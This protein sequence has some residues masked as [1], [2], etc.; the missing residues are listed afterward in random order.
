MQTDLKAKS[1]DDL[2]K[3]LQEAYHRISEL[4]TLTLPSRQARRD[5]NHLNLNTNYEESFIDLKSILDTEYIQDMMSDFQKLTGAAFAILDLNGNILV[6]SGWQDICT[7]F[8]RKHPESARN[9]SKSDFYLEKNA[10]PGRYVA[11]RCGNNLWDIVTPLYIGKTHVGNIYAGQF[12]YDDETVDVNKF[13]KQAEKYGFDPKKYLEA[14]DKVPRFKRTHVEHLMDFLLKITIFISNLG[15]QNLQLNKVV[16][17]LQLTAG[18]L[19]ESDRHF[20]ALITQA[21]IP[22]IV[23]DGAG[24]VEI[25]NDRFEATFGYTR[26][27]IPNKNSWLGLA[28]PYAS[29]RVNANVW[30]EVD[31]T[32]ITRKDIGDTL[33][34]YLVTCK[35]GKQR[36]TEATCSWIGDNAI[37]IY[38]DI[39]DRKQA[40]RHL[41]DSEERLKNLYALSPI[42]IFLSVP[43]GYYLDANKALS[44]ILGYT[45][46]EDLIFSVKSISKQTFFNPSDWN[47]I[48]CLLKKD[49]VMIN[50]IV[51]RKKKD[52]S[53][54]WVLMNM[55]TVY[56]KSGSISHFDGFTVDITEQKNTESLLQIQYNFANTLLEALPNPVFYKNIHGKYIGCNKAWEELLGIP[57]KNIIG[58]SVF[59]VFPQQHA[60]VYRT[61]DDMLFDEEVKQE[62]ETTLP[63][64][65]GARNVILSKAIYH[66]AQKNTVGLIGVVT[67]ITDRK[68]EQAALAESEN[69]LRNIFENAPIGI[70]QSTPNGRYRTVNA[71]FSR[72]VG[73]ENPQDMIDSIE[74][75]SSLYIDPNQREEFKSILTVNGVVSD[76]QMHIRR[77]DGKTMWMSAYAKAIHNQE[78]DSIY[79]DGFALDISERKKAEE[80]VYV[81]KNYLEEIVTERTRALQDEIKERQRIQEELY[82]AKE[83]AEAANQAKSLFLANMS[84]ELRTPLNSVLGFSQIM[85]S[86][87]SLNKDQK[88]NLGII[89]RSGEHLL[90]LINDVLDISKIETGKISLTEN[91]FDL[92]ATLQT[93]DEMLSARAKIKGLKFAIEIDSAVP[94]MI[95]ADEK[96]L[97]QVIVNLAGNALKFTEAGWVVI[98]VSASED[99]LFFEVEDTG[100]GI[101]SDEIPRLFERF[102]QGKVNR[103]GAGLGLYISQKLVELMGGTIN[104]ISEIN[105]GSTFYFN[106]FYTLISRLQIYNKK[107]SLPVTGFTPSSP[108]L[109]ILVVED[110]IESQSLMKKFLQPIGFIVD[111]AE[112]GEEALHLYKKHRPNLVLMDM[113]MPIMDGYEATRRIRE[114]EQDSITPIIAVTASAFEEDKQKIFDAGVNDI[115]RKPVRSDELY[116]TIRKHLQINYIYGEYLSFSEKNLDQSLVMELIK[117]LPV[118]LNNELI[119]ALNNLDLDNFKNLLLDVSNYSSALADFLQQLVDNYEINSLSNV[120]HPLED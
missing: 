41:Q 22:I 73:F 101:L 71:C 10:C 114:S 93:I 34:E 55:R 94:Q 68:K 13:K 78:N 47:D 83:V 3:E 14:L 69:R 17:R 48:V 50:K 98:R 65:R 7:K 77:I 8:H 15:D 76:F 43:D 80:E 86:D 35:D 60:S 105:R 24:N 38:V 84:H 74:D 108:I 9:C 30:H 111:T 85:Q 29:S 46:P 87:P 16:N 53:S 119:V 28:V 75:I 91:N 109:R 90:G 63:S 27:D 52:G 112:N 49:G 70:F 2:I 95:K 1:K 23:F 99:R 118:A 97:R 61:K 19:R 92:Y 116:E 107:T 115:I 56:N 45:S 33:P 37:I 4:E 44:D 67:D 104:V 81:Y 64:T 102:E 32:Q 72:M 26:E 31:I 12:F 36:I 113:L 120:F 21:P 106:I 103:D 57:R 6:A 11:Y 51:R 54:I 96:R 79:Y 58:K 110:Q 100:P 42:G 25:V 39:T 66:D 40:E 18:A 89:L 59:E 62:Y 20:R 82:H 5:H 117:I 88:D